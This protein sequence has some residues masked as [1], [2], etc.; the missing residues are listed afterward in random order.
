MTTSRSMELNKYKKPRLFTKREFKVTDGFL[1][2]LIIDEIYDGLYVRNPAHPEQLLSINAPAGQF[3]LKNS[4]AAKRK[5]KW[6]RRRPLIA[7]VATFVLTL[8][9]LQFFGGLDLANLS[10]EHGQETIQ[11]IMNSFH[12]T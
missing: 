8:V 5:L 4:E 6:R 9:V 2:S 7:A 10:L 12:T 3:A 1:E 11:N